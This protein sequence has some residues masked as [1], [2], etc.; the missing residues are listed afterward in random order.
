M[1]EMNDTNVVIVLFQ[2]SVVA[3]GI[4]KSLQMPDIM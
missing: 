1:N 3:K 4:E 2:Y